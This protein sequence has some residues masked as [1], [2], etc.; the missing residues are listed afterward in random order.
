MVGEL[1]G[2]DKSYFDNVSL[3]DSDSFQVS[4]RFPDLIT[5]DEAVLRNQGLKIILP[6]PRKDTVKKSPFSLGVYIMEPPPT[7]C[8]GD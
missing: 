8:K 6:I 4:C 5:I 3:I 7:A 2:K 1:R